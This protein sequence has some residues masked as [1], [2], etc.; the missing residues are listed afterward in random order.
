MATA[1][2]SSWFA[3]KFAA[4][5]MARAGRHVNRCYIAGA[6]SPVDGGSHSVGCTVLL[7]EF[8]HR[9]RESFIPKLHRQTNSLERNNDAAGDSTAPDGR[10][11]TSIVVARGSRL[12]ASPAHPR[13]LERPSVSGS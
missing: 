9:L 3:A 5:V 1:S 8:P 11:P 10:N 2:A 13:V 4:D 6:V 7:A 12:S